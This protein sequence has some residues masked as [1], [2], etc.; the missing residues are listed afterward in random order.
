MQEKHTNLTKGQLRTNIY[1]TL[2]ESRESARY[3]A[4]K[5]F[6]DRGLVKGYRSVGVL[7]F[8]TSEI[9]RTLDGK[10]YFMK[11][12]EIPNKPPR[13]FNCRSKLAPIV[14]DSIRSGIRASKFG[15]TKARTYE[16][17]FNSI[18]EATKQKFMSPRKYKAYKNGLFNVKSLADLDGKLDVSEIK[19][20]LK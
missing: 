11:L 17:W 18:D 14:K 2:T 9:C 1:T 7:D 12:E 15:E 19:T 20:I 13:H 4:Y 10:E 8:R 16:E 6:E 5:T 3:A